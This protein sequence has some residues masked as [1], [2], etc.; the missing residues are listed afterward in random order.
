MRPCLQRQTRDAEIDSNVP[1]F[2]EIDSNVPLF[3][4]IDSNVPLFADRL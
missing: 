1:L 2:A 3:A 4:E